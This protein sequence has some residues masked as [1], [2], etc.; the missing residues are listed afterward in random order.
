VF[1]V[2]TTAFAGYMPSRKA[3][4]VDPIEILRG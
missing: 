1:G 2:S 4:K 3:G